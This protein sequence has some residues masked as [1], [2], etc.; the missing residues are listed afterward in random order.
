MSDLPEWQ[1]QVEEELA[2]VA[3]RRRIIQD[4]VGQRMAE[5]ERR[6]HAFGVLGD[7]VVQT[8][9][10]PRLERL[11]GY[12]ENARL[13]P[14]DQTA[15]YQCVCEFRHTHWL[16]A[17]ATLTLSVSSDARVEYLTS[18][19]ELQILPVLFSFEGRSEVAF[20]LDAVDEARLTDW[21]EGRMVAFVDTYLRLEDLEP[22]QRENLVTD[23][24]CGMRI[25][26]GYAAAEME[27][28]GKT[29]Y[30]CLKACREKFA[31]DPRR[32]LEG[33]RAEPL[34]PA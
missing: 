9:F 29:Y 13:L 19:Y 22:Y 16:P 28:H 32:Y 5:V 26:K 33:G 1:R 24:V 10:R 17:T 27:H 3:E 34:V 23:P 11:A 14:A 31:A 15:R 18:S 4:H 25:N 21:V 2:A 6:W 12:F 30:F 20:P 7:R 8:I